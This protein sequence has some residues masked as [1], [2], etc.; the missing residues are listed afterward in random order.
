MPRSDNRG[1]EWACGVCS[2][3]TL[4]LSAPLL[5]YSIYTCTGVVRDQTCMVRFE[6]NY[7]TISWTFSP[8]GN[9]SIPCGRPDNCIVDYDPPGADY[10]Q[11]ADDLAEYVG[12]RCYYKKRE[13]AI[14]IGNDN[15][16]CDIG[17]IVCGITVTICSLILFVL[18][19]GCICEKMRKDRPAADTEGVNLRPVKV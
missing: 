16:I 10:C 2:V 12:C 13:H 6:Q 18:A 7:T 15:T 17:I 11:F 1:C 8:A 5:G 3:L 19:G 14:I 9:A 4:L